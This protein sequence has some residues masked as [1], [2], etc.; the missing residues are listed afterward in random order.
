MNNNYKPNYIFK[1][2]LK[3]GI[4]DTL[5]EIIITSD[6]NNN[7]YLYSNG[8][9]DKVLTIKIDKLEE[10]LKKHVDK[11]KDLDPVLP[12]VGV[13]DGYQNIV[14]FKVNNKRY[15]FGWSNLAYYSQTDI[16]NSES[17]T[18]IF[19]F[20]FDIKVELNEQNKDIN[21]YFTLGK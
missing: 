14:D 5:K 17:L 21:K 18:V 20:L 11:L 19:N 8:K 15:N 16:D 12:Y 2:E 7:T 10:I 1:Y 4:M 6:E 3:V 13:L 9:E